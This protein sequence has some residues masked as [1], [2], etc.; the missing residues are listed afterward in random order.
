MWRLME[1]EVGENMLGNNALTAPGSG[2]HSCREVHALKS[3]L[4][5]IPELEE[6]SYL[7]QR[8][9]LRVEKIQQKS[10]YWQMVAGLTERLVLLIA[11]N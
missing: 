5:L 11:A 3:A 4:D 8:A 2:I 7:E 10:Y 6:L 9:G 1:L